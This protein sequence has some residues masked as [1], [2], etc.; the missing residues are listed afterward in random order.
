MGRVGG[1]RDVDGA[2]LLKSAGRITVP[3]RSAMICARCFISLWERYKARMSPAKTTIP[4]T[5]DEEASP[6]APVELRSRLG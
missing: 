5:T 6:R 4:N 1:T 2:Q 3:D